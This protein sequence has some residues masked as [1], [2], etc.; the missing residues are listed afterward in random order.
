MQPQVN[1]RAKFHKI[2]KIRIGGQQ[3][4]GPAM[5]KVADVYNS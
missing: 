1:N 5:A 2:D 3:D 4:Q